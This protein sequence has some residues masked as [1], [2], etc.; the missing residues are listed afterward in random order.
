MVAVHFSTVC[1][2]KC[3]FCYAADTL[4]TYQAPAEWSFIERTLRH[5]ASE[6]VREVLFVG[7]DPVV[8]RDFARSV[9]LAKSLG[10]TVSVL[11][12]SWSLRPTDQFDAILSHIDNCEA[13]VLGHNAALH[14]SITGQ[15][16]SYSVLVNNL[17]RIAKAG[18]SV[19]VCLNAMPRTLIHLFDTVAAVVET[20]G[21]PGSVSAGATI[22][23]LPAQTDG[24]PSALDPGHRR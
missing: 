21:V 2:A 5:L 17:Q 4:N 1:A 23:S 9:A 7:G 6:D 24:T 12:N 15:P 22:V 19:G 11:S 3:D 18:R 8:H 16:R 14:D 13:T 10:L 20:H